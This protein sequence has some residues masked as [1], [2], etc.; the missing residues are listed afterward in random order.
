M[1]I[2]CTEVLAKVVKVND[3]AWAEGK[4]E[5]RAEDLQKD[6]HLGKTK[7]EVTIKAEKDSSKS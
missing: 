2:I 1:E 6:L 7:K 5:K 4:A 3:Y